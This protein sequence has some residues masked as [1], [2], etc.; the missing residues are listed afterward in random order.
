[1]SI[2]S[3]DL[4]S[5]NQPVTDA[6]SL[7]LQGNL[8]W[9]ASEQ[10][11][12][13]ELTCLSYGIGQDSTA[14]LYR[15]AYDPAFRK[16]Y[17]PRRLLI[18]ASDTGDEHD[19]TYQYLDHVRDFCAEHQ[20]EFYFITPEMGFHNRTW[21]TLQAHYDLTSTCGSKAFRKSCTDTL[22]LTPFYAFLEK[23]IEREY[24]IPASRKKGLIRFARR[25][26]HPIRVIVGIAK[27]EESRVA[28]PSKETKRWR[29][30]AIQMSYPL[31]AEGMGRQE[32][33][34]YIRR[35]DQP[36][37]YPSACRR[38]PYTNEI[39]LVWLHRHDPETLA[40]WIRQEQNKLDKFAHLGEKNY[41]VWG[42]RT[43]P[44][45]LRDALAKY[46]GWSDEAINDHKFSHG[47][48]VASKY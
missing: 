17:A 32:C 2:S 15:L 46:G 10:E 34:E 40:D 3:H 48:C 1:M 41:G 45:V 20:L 33:Q 13:P 37:P 30:L 21:Q 47:H 44:E 26:G 23:W 25:F 24:K 42:R 31:I 9:L 14:I 5:R 36:V 27:G 7:C 4:L 18:L 8:P 35:V 6:S 39:E 22:K 38:C 28:D 29:R 12:E 11:L 19:H 43:L 16:M